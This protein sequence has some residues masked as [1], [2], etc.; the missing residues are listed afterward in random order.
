LERLGPFDPA[1][2]SYFDHNDF[3]MAVRK[4][5]GPIHVE[6]RSV[7]TYLPPPPLAISDVPFFMLRWSGRWIDASAAHFARKHGLSLKDPIFAGHYEYQQAQ[8]ARV[9]RHP[10]RAVRRI[11]GSRGLALMER[12][13]DQLLDWTITPYLGE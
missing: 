11:L 9:L 5:G 3:C 7:V 2:L 4:A 13:I 1:L 12:T 8:R 6:P 10:R